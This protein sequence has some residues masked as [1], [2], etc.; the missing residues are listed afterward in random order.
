MPASPGSAAA[1]LDLLQRCEAHAAALRGIHAQPPVPDAGSEARGRLCARIAELQQATLDMQ[2]QLD[3]E[4]EAQHNSLAAL[5]AEVSVLTEGERYLLQQHDA[6]VRRLAQQLADARRLH[7]MQLFDASAKRAASVAVADDVQ[8]VEQEEAQ[9]ADGV[10]WLREG[11]RIKVRDAIGEPWKAATV[12]ERLRDGGVM[13]RPEG[14]TKVLRFG[15]AEPLPPQ[16]TQ[17]SPSPPR[18]PWR[19]AGRH[20]KRSPSRRRSQSPREATGRPEWP[21]P[22]P[23]NPGDDDDAS[24]RPAELLRR[25]RS[26]LLGRAEPTYRCPDDPEP[27]VISKSPGEQAG[28]VWDNRTLALAAVSPGSAA[29]RSGGTLYLGRC[30]SHVDGTPVS[31]IEQAA[32]TIRAASQVHLRFYSRRGGDRSPSMSPRRGSPAAGRRQ[33][34][35]SPAR[36]PPPRRRVASPPR[37]SPASKRSPSSRGPSRGRRTESP[38]R[39]QS[40]GGYRL[41]SP[42]RTAAASGRSPPPVRPLPVPPAPPLPPLLPNPCLPSIPP[43]PPSASSA[44]VVPAA[45]PPLPTVAAAVSA[46]WRVPPQLNQLPRIPPPPKHVDPAAEPGAAAVHRLSS[47]PRPPKHVGRRD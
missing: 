40:G 17:A 41:P 26:P 6:A 36:S 21:P 30:L 44:P 11:A 15:M 23:T 47:P 20:P 3:E 18:P 24:D 22:S 5:R 1:G 9:F 25:L 43:P 39:G 10:P 12:V 46:A 38:T 28:L 34:S 45:S 42:P 29:M 8:L 13:A 19:P 14:W 31:G 35:P 2:R 16:P 37:R 27:L 32:E 33:L 7:E 4:A